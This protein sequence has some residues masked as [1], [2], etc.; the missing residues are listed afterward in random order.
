MSD[1]L[2]KTQVFEDHLA[3]EKSKELTFVSHTENSL[4]SNE[5]EIINSADVSK[6]SQSHVLIGDDDISKEESKAQIES[7]KDNSLA[8]YF[9]E[10]INSIQA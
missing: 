2:K 10:T 3:Q 6:V 8:E 5:I 1:Q 9:P 4:N 7:F